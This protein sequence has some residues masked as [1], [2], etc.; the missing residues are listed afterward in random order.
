MGQVSQNHI[1]PGAGA[2]RILPNAGVPGAG[3]NEVQNLEISGTP[4]GGTFKLA[5]EN[6]ITSAITWSSTTNTLLANIQAALDALP[7]LGANGC[8]A[9]D[10]DL[11]SGVGNIAL[12]FGAAREK[13]NV[14][15]ITVSLN[16]LTSSDGQDPATL[17]V[18][19][20]TPGVT[21]TFR[22]WPAGQAVR[23]T[24]NKKLYV[25]TGTATAPTWTVA[26]SQS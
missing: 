26:G 21:A 14:P 11:L 6:Q 5:F 15:T 23:D 4:N 22:G 24:T 25:N 19:V 7:S 17:A 2:N 16:S 9:S 3:T 13:E 10:V 12:T 1:A 18:T 8:V 20:T